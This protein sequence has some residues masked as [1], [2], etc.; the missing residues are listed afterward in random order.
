MQ[1]KARKNDFLKFQ[2]SLHDN[3]ATDFVRTICSTIETYF[4]NE[5]SQI[6]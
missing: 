5:N 1:R 4:S 6:I 2:A 3:I